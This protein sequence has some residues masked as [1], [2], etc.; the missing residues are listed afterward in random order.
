MSGL[1]KQIRF[2]GRAGRGSFQNFDV[3]CSPA[4]KKRY[5]V[6]SRGAPD[7]IKVTNSPIAANSFAMEIKATSAPR[8]KRWSP[9]KA[10]RILIIVVQG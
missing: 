6:F 4:C 7:P 3:Q 10:N 9:G 1:R 5:A 2:E 8:L